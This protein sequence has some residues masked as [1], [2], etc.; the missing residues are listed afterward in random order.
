MAWQRAVAIY[1]KTIRLQA[2]T[3][4]VLIIKHDRELLHN[5]FRFRPAD[6]FVLVIFC[7]HIEETSSPIHRKAS[8]SNKTRITME[9]D[10][11]MNH[12]EI[13]FIIA[14]NRW[15]CM[16][17]SVN[18]PSAVWYLIWW[19]K[20]HSSTCHLIAL[21]EKNGTG[22]TQ[23]SCHEQTCDVARWPANVWHGCANCLWHTATAWLLS[24]PWHSDTER[25]ATRL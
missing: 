13:S 18:I 19:F 23:L 14:H 8:H 24:S 4:V 7:N 17:H 15:N 12:Q 22:M 3:F 5:Y 11:R 1:F 25:P 20:S 10:N 21:S 9:R 16:A 2:K 6:S